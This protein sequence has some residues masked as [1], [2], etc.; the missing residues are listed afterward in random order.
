[1]VAVILSGGAGTRL[2]PVS[3][4]QYPKPFMKLPDGQSLLQKAFLRAARVGAQRVLTVT[5]LEYYY[6]TA[7]EYEALG[8]PEVQTSFVVEPLRRNTAPAIAMAAL[9]VAEHNPDEVM[10][11]LSADHLILREEAF[12]QAVTQAQA[13]AQE[14]YLVTFGIQPTYPATN[15]GYIEQGL[16]LQ[17]GAYRVARFV[18]K[19]DQQTA[20]AYLQTGRFFWNAGIFCFKATTYL[21]ALEHLQPDMYK[22]ALDCWQGSEKGDVAYLDANLFKQVP[23]ESVDYAVM[24]KAAQVAVVPADLGWSDLGSWDAA[25][26]MVPP[27]AAGN[28]VF[29]EAVLLE[30]TNTFVQTEDRV[31][32][33]IGA[34]DLVIVDTRDA[35]LVARR[36]KVQDVK[37]VVEQLTHSKHDTVRRHR[38]IR[39]PWGSYLTLEE[40]SGFKIRRVVVK[41]GQALSN[42]LHHHRSEHWTVLRG[43]AQVWLDGRAQMLRQGE[44]VSALAGVAHQL[45]NPGLLDLV[46]IEVQ[47][48]EYLGEDDVKRLESYV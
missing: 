5:G 11:V 28:R 4:E 34:S 25:A 15:F 23:S 3:R 48:G 7:S 40:T 6:S 9:W 26:L 43:T 2:W 8:M 41:P 24:E 21:Q 14:G 37:K 45:I 47:T 46:L 22:A 44:S 19:P 33:V 18:E 20:E 17:D 13:I 12:A 38:T 36:D 29:G 39:R 35:L 32:A 10:L 27:D 16:P 1:M 30:T 42:H 31:V